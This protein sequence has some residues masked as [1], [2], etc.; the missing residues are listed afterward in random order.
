MMCIAIWI[1]GYLRKKRLV[2]YFCFSSLFLQINKYQ[3]EILEIEMSCWWNQYGIMKINISSEFKISEAADSSG[4]SGSGH[5]CGR[6]V[7]RHR[8]GQE[9]QPSPFFLRQV[10]FVCFVDHC[11]RFYKQQFYHRYEMYSMRNLVN[12]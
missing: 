12:N 8:A 11:D 9:M 1:Q 7:E 3:S 10:G 2:L 4:R 6:C 5:K